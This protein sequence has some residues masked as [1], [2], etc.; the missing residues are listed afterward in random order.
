MILYFD[1]QGNA[2]HKTSL[3][4]FLLEVEQHW[5]PCSM[6]A[7]SSTGRLCV[8]HGR[9]GRVRLAQWEVEQEAESRTA[10]QA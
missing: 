1:L 9:S 10:E 7:T 6:H 3:N 2:G 4:S 8:A 5:S